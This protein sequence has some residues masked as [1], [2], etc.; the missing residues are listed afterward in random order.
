[1][2]RELHLHYQSDRWIP[3]RIRC[4]VQQDE[5]S[6][7]V[8]G[9]AAELASPWADINAAITDTSMVGLS[10]GIPTDLHVGTL[11]FGTQSYYQACSNLTEADA[12]LR[13]GVAEQ[14]LRLSQANIASQSPVDALEALSDGTAAMRRLGILVRARG[15]IGRA[16]ASLT[17]EN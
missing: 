5:T 9:L 6:L 13:A 7:S 1:V 11:T 3:Y 4:A 12:A 15:Y 8:P 2:V 10:L 14:E 17:S 16:A